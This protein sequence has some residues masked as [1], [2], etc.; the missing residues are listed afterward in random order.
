MDRSARHLWL[1]GHLSPVTYRYVEGDPS[2]I[3]DRCGFKYRHSQLRKEWT[4]LMVCYG[5]D[6]CGCWEPRHPQDFV[7]GVQ[8]K[9]SFPNP[10]PPPADVFVEPGDITAADL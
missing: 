8:D 7:K 1:A 6:T 10:R 4:G 3:C 9:Q 5:G 2:A